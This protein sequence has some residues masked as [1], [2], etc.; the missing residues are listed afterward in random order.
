MAANSIREQIIVQVKSELDEVASLKT[1][2][3]R[4]PSKEDLQNFAITQLPVV[5]IVAGLPKPDPHYVPRGPARKDVFISDL[6]LRLFCYFQ[7]NVNPDTTLSSILDD[8]WAALYS[9]TTKGGLAISTDLKPEVYT[10]FWDP[11]YAFMIEA[12]IKYSHTTGGI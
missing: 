8:L 1:V 11:Y 4:L 2:V 5:A 3:R 6:S 12:I 10:D 7:D 9:D